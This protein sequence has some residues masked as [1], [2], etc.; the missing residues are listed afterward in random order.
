MVV[1]EDRDQLSRDRGRI[2]EDCRHHPV[3]LV[4]TNAEHGAERLLDRTRGELR[5]RPFHQRHEIWNR[6]ESTDVRFI[7][8]AWHRYGQCSTR[9]YN[10]PIAGSNRRFLIAR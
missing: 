6:N 7:E 2:R 1:L 8:D 5:Q 3:G 9:A 10:R 4:G